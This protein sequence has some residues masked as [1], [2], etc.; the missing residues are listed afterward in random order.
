M[1]DLGGTDGPGGKEGLPIVETD[2][3]PASGGV[4]WISRLFP[5][6]FAGMAEGS[7]VKWITPL[8]SSHR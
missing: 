5:L 7:S 3:F 6:N 4:F 2:G 8:S 1:D